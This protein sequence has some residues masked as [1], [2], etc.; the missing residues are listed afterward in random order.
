MC[1]DIFATITTVGSAIV[2]IGAVY[3]AAKS[4]NAA[5]KSA[6]VAVK[7]LHRS[8][9]RELIA[10][11]HELIAE[12]LRIQSLV[13]DLRSEHK[14]SFVG[15]GSCGS[16]RYQ[17]QAAVFDRDIARA[18][19][20]TKEAKS[21]VSGQAELLAAADNDLDLM[22]GRIEAARSQLQTIREAMSRQLESVRAQTLYQRERSSS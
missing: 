13:I 7:A 3:I 1:A 16:T 4:A 18:A 6:A 22:Q 15:N 17:T 2:S 9:V 8:A 21:L 14:S 10:E 20:F 11:C 12:E 5:E 19:E